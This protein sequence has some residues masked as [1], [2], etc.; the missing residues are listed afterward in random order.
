MR[1]IAALLFCAGLFA[2]AGP[3]PAQP[4]EGKGKGPKGKDQGAPAGR[5]GSVEATAARLMAFDTNGDG[6]LTKDELNDGRL[7]ALFE[8]A[9]ADKDGFVT[10]DELAALL[11]KEAAALTGGAGAPKGGFPGFP[12]GP[13]GGFRPPRPGEIFPTFLQDALELTAP[14]KKELAA[15][16]KELD[17][18][19][20]KLL[21]EE[22]RKR[23]KE[24]G[25]GPPGGFPFPG[26]PPTGDFPFPFPG[27]GG[28]GARP[29]EPAGARDTV[30]PPKVVVRA[31]PVTAANVR[32]AVEAALPPLWAAVEGHS[33]RHTCFTCHNH[34]VPAVA[35]AAARARG[36]DVPEKKLTE[37][38]KFV[39]DDLERNRPRFERGQGPGPPPAGGETD[40]TCY[41]LL[42]LDA[43]G[44]AGN[45][46]TAAT[47]AYTLGNQKGRDFWFTF[48]GRAPTEASHF[49]TTALNVRGLKRFGDAAHKDAIDKRATA[50][51]EWMLKT[52]P[53]D[54]EDRVFQVI[55]LRAAGAT[56]EQVQRAAKDLLSAQ[57]RDGGWG[58]LDR[59]PSDAYATATALWAL[60]D[61]GG[62]PTDAEPY[63]NGLAFLLG[64]QAT[65]GTWHVRTRS[66]PIQRYF[67]AGFPYER[68]QFIST[69]A[70]G[71]AA[72]AL[73]LALPK[74]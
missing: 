46:A 62:L 30:A 65:D 69:A 3:S 16:Q 15:L 26:G 10:K 17:A 24:L 70:T 2:A 38:L 7:A 53:R 23:L 49:T 43:L 34:A 33:E 36:F 27:A 37:L 71:W 39:T 29:Q 44:F 47:V 21:T 18:K 51:R 55:G 20:D 32:K 56:D 48:A 74:K 12:G 58:Q 1:T 4:P 35:F 59:M 57:R 9:D 42:A 72:T 73:A 22:Q 31:V 14:Q 64:T 61:S 67:D 41:S 50:A 6:K 54:T 8:R 5:A 28:G 66:R 25:E 52:A 45:K 13:G 40:N 19:L 68:D 60:H 63:R 11:T